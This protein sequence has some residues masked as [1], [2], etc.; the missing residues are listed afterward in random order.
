MK[1]VSN[2]FLSC[3][4]FLRYTYASCKQLKTKLVAWIANWREK[5]YSLNKQVYFRHYQGLAIFGVSLELQTFNC[6]I[7]C[8][9]KS[10]WSKKDFFG[11]IFIILYFIYY[12]GFYTS[13]SDSSILESVQIGLGVFFTKIVLCKMVVLSFNENV[14]PTNTTF[15]NH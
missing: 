7:N 13:F 3:I 1:E 6:Y 5:K 8:S 12:M 11:F 2:L 4:F 14:S 15:D 9:K 10:S